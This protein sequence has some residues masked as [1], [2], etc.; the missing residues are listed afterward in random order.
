MAETKDLSI[1]KY[2]AVYDM[3]ITT[4]KIHS[5]T[6]LELDRL[7]EHT[8]E[9]Y[10]EVIRKVLSIIRTAK[11]EPKL[12]KCAIEQIE[13]S[14]EQVRKGKYLTLEQVEKRFGL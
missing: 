4:I 2:T 9:S 14:R 11:K 7:R 3:A 8:S 5:D 13:K 1:P 6:K 10:D 12:S